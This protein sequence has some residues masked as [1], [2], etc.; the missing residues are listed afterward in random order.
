MY[1][2]PIGSTS[3]RDEAFTAKPE[4][5]EYRDFYTLYGECM[6]CWSRVEMSLF[7]IYILLLDASDY[8]VASSVFHSTIGFRTKLTMVNSIVNSSQLIN[9]DDIELW[10][11]LSDKLSKKS[12]RRNELA[13][14]T[15]CYG[16]DS[17]HKE[18]KLFITHIGKF[19]EGNR[20]YIHDLKQIRD[21]FEK[22]NAD[23]NIYWNKITP[24]V[25]QQ[26]TQQS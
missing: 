13:H 21:L 2:M 14:N 4:L 6:A 11:K 22:L 9:S 26:K 8:N 19:K 23:I 15:V 1:F 17:V 18:R 3:D 16:R 7:S 10:K 20:I 24:T 5:N 12:R 25:N